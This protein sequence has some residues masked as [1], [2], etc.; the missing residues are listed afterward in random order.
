MGYGATFTAQ[1]D[2]YVGTIP[3]GYADGMLRKLGGQEVLVGGERAKIIGRICMDQSMILLPK[4][5]NIG[6][7]VVLIGRQGFKRKLH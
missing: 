5:Y 4:A 2:I 1:E 6:E 7:P 3:I